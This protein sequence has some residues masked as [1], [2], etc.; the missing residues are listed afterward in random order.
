MQ[1]RTEEKS[2]H[3]ANFKQQVN[4]SISEELYKSFKE[5]CNSYGVSMTAVITHNILE[6]I[7]K[8]DG[9]MPSINEKGWKDGTK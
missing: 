2:A 4:I 6:F 1:L 7:D 5:K 9:K 3:Y 8:P